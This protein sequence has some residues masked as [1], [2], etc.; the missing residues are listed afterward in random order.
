MQ[1]ALPQDTKDTAMRKYRPIHVLRI[2]LRH[3]HNRVALARLGDRTLRDIGI[4]RSSI[5][6]LSRNP[7]A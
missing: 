7:V 1:S 4:S 3:R 2:W 5:G 6:Y